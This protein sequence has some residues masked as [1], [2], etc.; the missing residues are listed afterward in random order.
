M[1]R[2]PPSPAEIADLIE[3]RDPAIDATDVRA[4]VA[5]ALIR[6]R[7][8]AEREG[9]SYD[10]LASG[11]PATSAPSPD[12]L[13]AAIERLQGAP[14]HPMTSLLLTPSTTPLLG[15]LFRR[16]RALVHNVAI[17]YVNRSANTQHVFNQAA[18]GSI[19]ALAR[20]AESAGEL[21][22]LKKRVSS[23]EREI[24]ELRQ[25]IAGEVK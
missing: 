21:D 7:A 25:Q 12:A 17:F 2:T 9:L 8:W 3:I 23:L 10:A 16:F 19:Y 1:T 18:A 15:G 22:A 13:R 4:R 5:D 11:Q 6:R 14:A 24:R 20:A